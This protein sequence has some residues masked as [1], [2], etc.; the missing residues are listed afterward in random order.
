MGFWCKKEKGPWAWCRMLA[1]HSS[2]NLVTHV[3]VNI[4]QV[5]AQE[6]E[7]IPI[8]LDCYQ[9]SRFKIWLVRSSP[10]FGYVSFGNLRQQWGALNYMQSQTLPYYLT[11]SFTDLGALW[12]EG[13]SGVGS[14]PL[15]VIP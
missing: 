5:R 2:G 1:W 13:A 11:P 10:A 8:L 15:V 7:N 14:R 12:R 4:A 3:P 6:G 9:S